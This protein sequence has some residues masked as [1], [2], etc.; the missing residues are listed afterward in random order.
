MR[1]NISQQKGY[2]VKSRITLSAIFCHNDND[3]RIQLLTK[4]YQNESPD[5]LHNH[6]GRRRPMV[7][8]VPPCLRQG[9][10]QPTKTIGHPFCLQ[11]G[12]GCRYG[13]NGCHMIRGF[14]D[15]TSNKSLW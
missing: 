10:Q 3:A 6:G 7:V 1:R 13:I 2:V 4:H 12:M 14:S 9:I 15:A 8:L 11:V 5:A